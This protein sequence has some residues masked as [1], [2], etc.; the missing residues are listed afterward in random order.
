MHETKVRLRGGTRRAIVRAVNVARLSPVLRPLA[1]ARVAGVLRLGLV[2]LGVAGLLAGPAG[3]QE[4][5]RPRSGVLFGA[6]ITDR[7]ADVQLDSDDGRGTN[8]DLENDL[9][10]EPDIDVGRVGGYHWFNNRHRFDGA[11]FD[12]SRDGGRH[13]SETIT[14][15]GETFNVDTD[16]SANIDFEVIKADYT[17]AALTRPTGF[18]GVTGGLYVAETSFSLA[19]GT[20]AAATKNVTAP[21]PVLGLR[22]EYAITRRLTVGGAVQWFKLESDD[23]EGRL[24]DFYL[25]ADYRITRR[26]A[27]GLAYNDVSLDVE[28]EDRIGLNGT[29]D[30]SY[31]GIFLYAKL[32]LGAEAR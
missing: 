3:G 12:L 15:D 8:L 20:G 28:A 25:G 26:F 30:W 6:F 32:I 19:A 14:F 17:F 11:Y 16:L 4:R 9:G 2:I 21:L 5:Q 22:G 29:I 27:I 23:F 31:D 24:T 10:I 13:L 1:A 7:V 18:L